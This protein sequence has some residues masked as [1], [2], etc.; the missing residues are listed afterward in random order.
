MLGAQAAP[1]SPGQP[2][3]T[4]DH[5]VIISASMITCPAII[6]SAGSTQF[7]I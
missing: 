1:G 2:R 5:L 4:P 7:S 3:A 6:Y